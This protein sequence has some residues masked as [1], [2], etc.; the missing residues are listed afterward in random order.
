MYRKVIKI[1]FLLL[2]LLPSIAL[3]WT[4][5]GEKVT[6]DLIYEWQDNNVILFKTSLGHICYIPENEKNMYSL[7]LS[8]MATGKKASIHCHDTEESYGGIMAHR[9]HRII[10]FRN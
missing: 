10:A 7:V 5:S 4:P 2:S 9:V 8:L 6:I 3:S 1:L